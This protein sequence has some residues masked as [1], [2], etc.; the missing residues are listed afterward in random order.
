MCSMSGE[1]IARESFPDSEFAP[2]PI[3]GRRVGGGRTLHILRAGGKQSSLGIEGYGCREEFSTEFTNLQ[4][5]KLAF[6][7]PIIISEM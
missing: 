2:T 6:S 5:I 1:P 3:P 4:T 7:R